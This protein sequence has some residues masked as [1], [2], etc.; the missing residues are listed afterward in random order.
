MKSFQTH[1][2]QS[3]NL[4]TTMRYEVRKRH[5]LFTEYPSSRSLIC[6]KFKNTTIM[7][8]KDGEPSRA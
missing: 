3:L 4:W 7:K 8:L 5:E 1:T 2:H 6:L